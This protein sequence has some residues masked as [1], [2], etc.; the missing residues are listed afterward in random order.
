LVG[1]LV[2]W[3]VSQWVSQSVSYS[4]TL[5]RIILKTNCN[6]NLHN[7]YWLAFLIEGHNVPRDV[8]TGSLYILHS[9]TVE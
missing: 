8:V 7:I 6:L 3:L 9:V 2:G 1:W 5:F 4:V